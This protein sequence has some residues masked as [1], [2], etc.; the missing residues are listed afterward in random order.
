MIVYRPI[1]EPIRKKASFDERL[2]DYDSGL[3]LAW[4]VGRQ[5][6]INNPDIANRVNNGELPQLNHKGGHSKKLKA[7]DFKYGTFQYLA[8]IQG[9]KGKNLDINTTRDD[10]M[11]LIC[12]R[13]GMKTIFTSDQNKYK[14]V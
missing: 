7:C 2:N 5:T 9:I 12:S 11:T 14:E 6:A 3:I 13:T 4:E 10:G 1:S 8:E